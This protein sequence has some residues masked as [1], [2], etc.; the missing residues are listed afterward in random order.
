MAEYEIR[1]SGVHY[2]ANGDSVA[3]QK[4]TEEMHM[5]TRELLSRIDRV[6]PIVTLSPDPENRVHER[7]LQARAL[8][9]RIG[10]VALECVDLVWDLL[11]A[12]GKPMLLAKVKEWPPINVLVH[13]LKNIY[14]FSVE[15]GLMEKHAEDLDSMDLPFNWRYIPIDYPQPEDYWPEKFDK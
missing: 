6:R 12:S 9:K 2:A 13:Y 15:N 11:R 4:D 10:R 14:L 1:I 8:G 5:R 7:A 3:G